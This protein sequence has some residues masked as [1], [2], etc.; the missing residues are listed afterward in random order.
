MTTWKRRYPKLAAYLDGMFDE[1]SASRCDELLA[2]DD[3]A[4]EAE[5][6]FEIL[7]IEVV[8]AMGYYDLK[9]YDSDPTGKGISL[10]SM[11]EK[12]ACRY[13]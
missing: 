6:Q 11:G 8:S 10:I 9:W 4:R 13:L 2:T 3:E 12:I 1:S 7:P 5:K